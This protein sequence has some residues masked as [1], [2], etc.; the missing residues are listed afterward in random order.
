MACTCAN[1]SLRLR[2][3][4]VESEK[5]REEIRWRRWL[6]TCALA[7]GNAFP[8]PVA[9]GV[10]R[11]VLA[12]LRRGG[13]QRA[14]NLKPHNLVRE[15]LRFDTASTGQDH[16]DFATLFLIRDSIL[17]HAKGKDRLP[18]KSPLLLQDAIDFGLDPVRTDP[19]G[20]NEARDDCALSRAWFGLPLR[21]SWRKPSRQ[22]RSRVPSAQDCHLRPRLFLASA[23]EAV[24]QG[25]PGAEVQS[26]ILVGIAGAQCR[27]RCQDRQRTAAARL[28]G[29][30]DLGMRGPEDGHGTASPHPEAS[31]LTAAVPDPGLAAEPDADTNE[32]SADEHSPGQLLA[33]QQPAC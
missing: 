5:R 30:G 16:P 21:A 13:G 33:E 24:V 3:F 6:A 2:A 19:G 18:S 32:A 1:N 29:D 4:Y 25:R 23:C 7:A 31:W 14:G 15:R 17:K 26:W 9:A 12:S 20:W 10:A 8:S 22:A 11:A 27:A 28:A